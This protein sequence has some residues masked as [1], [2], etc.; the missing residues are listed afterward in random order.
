MITLLLITGCDSA[1]TETNNLP[2][3]NK[4]INTN[5]KMYSMCASFHLT[6]VEVISYFKSADQVDEGEFHHSAMLLPCS[7]YGKIKGIRYNWEI[8]AGGAGTLYNNKQR[9]RFLCKVN[10]VC[11]YLLYVSF[12]THQSQDS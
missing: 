5:D 8:Y 10:A 3:L 11:V 1:Q 7:Y 2:T 12:T 4:K 9:K 6:Q